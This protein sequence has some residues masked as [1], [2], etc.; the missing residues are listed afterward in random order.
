MNKKNEQAK[1]GLTMVAEKNQNNSKSLAEWYDGNKAMTSESRLIEGTPF[2]LNPLTDSNQY[3]V[4]MGRHILTE[5]MDER[6]AEE[7]CNR[8]PGW[9]DIIM[10]ASCVVQDI[11]TIR[12][13]KKL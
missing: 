6:K 13:G 2:R 4:S 10:I 11:I 9:D 7:W 5:P 12:E 8:T 1:S 3:F